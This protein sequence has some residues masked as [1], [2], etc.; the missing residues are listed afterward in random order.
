M[1]PTIFCQACQAY[2]GPTAAKCSGCGRD[3]G[4]HEI[5]PGGDQ[6][7]WQKQKENV[8]FT[9]PVV[10][11]DRIYLNWWTYHSGGGVA[12]LD[13]QSGERVW[14]HHTKDRAEGGVALQENH[15]YFGTFGFLGKGASL[16]C[17]NLKG[18]LEWKEDL[19][20]GTRS[21]PLMQ[22]ARL[23][24]GSTD[25][26][27]LCFDNRSGKP[28]RLD[29]SVPTMAEE[30]WLTMVDRD[31]LAF[32]RGGQVMAIDPSRLQPRW[33]KL[34]D[35][36]TRITTPPCAINTDVYIGIEGGRLARLD[37]RRKKMKIFADGW[38][39]D[40]R[41]AP[42]HADG[43]MLVG[44]KDRHLWAFNM[45]G[46]E[47]WEKSKFNHSIV[48]SSYVEG[49]L[50]IVTANG[51]E[52]A[53]LELETGREVWRYQLEVDRGL[54]TPPLLDDGVVYTG[55][56]AGHLVALPWHLGR[57]S[58]AADHLKERKQLFEAGCC[59]AAAVNRATPP[60]ERQRLYEKAEGCWG[61]LGEP[62]WA[63]RMWDGLGEEREAAKAYARA[64]ET[65]RGLEN[66]KGA[67]FFI[68]AS[69]YYWRLADGQAEADNCNNEAAKLAK[70]PN[71]RLVGWNVPRMTQGRKDFISFRVE[72]IGYAPARNLNFSLACSLKE[73][74]SCSIPAPLMPL[75][76]YE[77]TIEI[78]PTKPEDSLII[79]AEYVDEEMR[80]PPFSSK[81]ALDIEAAPAPHVIKM[82]DMVMGDVTV[83]NPNNEPV[84]F[85]VGDQVM[86][87]VKVI[88]GNT[89]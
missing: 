45:D 39:K 65:Y 58:W 10:N 8:I 78:T 40:L 20:G 59:Y 9:R 70:M 31:L 17:Y 27:I 79:E 56:D 1:I 44:A 38:E 12:A 33:P 81:V 43:R 48:N 7:L 14:E 88:L 62:E 4:D 41:A 61:E 82:G 49:G 74:V 64:A 76:Y 87:K 29:S 66:D 68:R 54:M 13:R 22:E 23:F 67:E 47:A 36:G 30:I 63:A 55:S 77:I 25:G 60:A 85:V 50:A 34:L 83:V 24:I 75:S 18:D 73:P 2:I 46:I 52:V 69:G 26:Q 32:S 71:L 5:M 53:C 86:S 11:G 89:E 51:G 80:Q 35:L 28:V 16:Y 3:R 72:N 21:A 57:Y 19:P 42:V 37:T 84:E 15:L 6:P